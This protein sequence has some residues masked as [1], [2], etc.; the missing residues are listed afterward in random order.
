MLKLTLSLTVLVLMDFLC[1]IVSYIPLFVERSSS[2]GKN[3]VCKFIGCGRN[4]KF[5]YVVMQLQ[6]SHD[7]DNHVLTFR[8]ANTYPEGHL[9][10]RHVRLC[11]SQP[12]APL[13]FSFLVSLQSSFGSWCSPS[14]VSCQTHGGTFRPGG[15]F[16]APRLQPFYLSPPTFIDIKQTF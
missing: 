9:V 4:D 7:V 15:S 2:P 8:G 16:T 5:N 10:R 1:R 6:V 12:G 3:H 13:A 11:V 14:S